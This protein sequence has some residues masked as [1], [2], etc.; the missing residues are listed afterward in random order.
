MTIE[1]IKANTDK[2]KAIRE[3]ILSSL[4]APIEQNEEMIDVPLY[5]DVE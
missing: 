3:E 5:E 2:V 1:M 4:S